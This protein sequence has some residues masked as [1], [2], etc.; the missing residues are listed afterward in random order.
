MI[1]NAKYGKCTIIS[2]GTVDYEDASFHND[3]YIFPVGYEVTRKYLSPSDAT[4]EDVVYKA[5]VLKDVDGS[6]IFEVENTEN[7]VKH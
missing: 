3:R 6:A 4:K 7:G 1:V 2:L 5:K